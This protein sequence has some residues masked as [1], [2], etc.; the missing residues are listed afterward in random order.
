MSAL[1]KCRAS[2]TLSVQAGGFTC[3][4]LKLG[5]TKEQILVTLAARVDEEFQADIAYI[6]GAGVAAYCPD[7][8]YKL[9]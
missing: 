6:V 2:C 7:Q 9:R 8:A 4:R 5:I 3:R 1:S